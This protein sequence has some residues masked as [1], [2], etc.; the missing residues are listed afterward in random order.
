MQAVCKVTGDI[1]VR[2][3][4]AS[5]VQIL[6]QMPIFLHGTSVV[7]GIEAIRPT[8]QLPDDAHLRLTRACGSGQLLGGTI[9]VCLGA[10]FFHAHVVWKQY[11][12]QIIERG[13][14]ANAFTFDD[15]TC[16]FGCVVIL[17]LVHRIAWPDDS[18]AKISTAGFRCWLLCAAKWPGT[19]LPHWPLNNRTCLQGASLW[20]GHN[21]G[22]RA[23]FCHWS[24]ATSN[25]GPGGSLWDWS[26][27]SDA[28]SNGYGLQ[29]PGW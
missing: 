29:I 18:P 9:V 6:N 2:L 4:Q 17:I 23:S 3:Q 27:W 8:R 15:N 7:R 10:L 28:T 14:D 19:L 11:P 5:H 26:A 22:P 1:V 25:E 13:F 16:N 24:D 20:Q 12:K 21:E